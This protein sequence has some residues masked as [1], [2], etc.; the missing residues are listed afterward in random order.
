MLANLADKNLLFWIQ[1]KLSIWNLYLTQSAC[2]IQR[3][4]QDFFPIQMW[5]VSKK[6]ASHNKERN[7]LLHDH[8]PK[9]ESQ[10]LQVKPPQLIL[11]TVNV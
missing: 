6:P 7:K 10:K 5:W 8:E 3:Q 11:T 1:A 9:T 4:G 2:E